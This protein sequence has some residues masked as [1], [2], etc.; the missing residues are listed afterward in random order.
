MM[1]RE[2][3]AGCRSATGCN[4]IFPVFFFPRLDRKL[5]RHQPSP[6]KATGR[7]FPG[8][9]ST[10]QK[11]QV[12]VSRFFPCD[13]IVSKERLAELWSGLVP[14]EN[15]RCQVRCQTGRVYATVTLQGD[16]KQ[17]NPQK[18]QLY[19]SFLSKTSSTWK[20]SHEYSIASKRWELRLTLFRK[21]ND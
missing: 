15:R 7:L 3:A 14:R 6:E 10:R 21:V 13:H 1:D 20:R 18:P 12:C 19:A 2:T 16:R 8:F 4:I 17:H 9:S 5:Q 11:M